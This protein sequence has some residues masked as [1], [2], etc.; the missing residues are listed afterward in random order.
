[1]I[2]L[3]MRPANERRR[4]IVTKSLIGWALTK[5]DPC[6]DMGACSLIEAWNKYEQC[7]WWVNAIQT[8]SN[9]HQ[10]LALSVLGKSDGWQI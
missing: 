7:Q 6:L 9:M 3:R 2:S 4:Y 8:A 10:A 1:M 5:T